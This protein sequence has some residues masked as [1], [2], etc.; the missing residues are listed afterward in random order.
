MR[1]HLRME[2][3]CPDASAAEPGAVEHVQRVGSYGLVVHPSTSVPQLLLVRLTDRTP[4]P[5]AWSLPGGRVEIGEHPADAVLRELHEET[6]LTGRLLGLLD[7]G[8]QVRDYYHA[9]RTDLLYHAIRILYRVEVERAGP[10]VVHDADGS[11][12][13]PTW[14]SVAD[15]AGLPLTPVAELALPHLPI[16]GGRPDPLD[17]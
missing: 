7:V 2:P 1:H 8:S 14:F 4:F 10:L 17:R 3:P 5:G 9:D 15:L 6:G 16:L 13:Q 11:S 12:D